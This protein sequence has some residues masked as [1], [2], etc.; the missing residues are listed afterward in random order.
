MRSSLYDGEFRKSLR[1][2]RP[3]GHFSLI[4]TLDPEHLTTYKNLYFYLRIIFTTFL[5][6]KPLLR[7]LLPGL[8]RSLKADSHLSGYRIQS[9]VVYKETFV[10]EHQFFMT[11]FIR[12]HNDRG[13]YTAGI[14]THRYRSR[15]VCLLR[16]IHMTSG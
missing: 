13:K 11:V 16:L 5:F 14:G 15:N 12:K 7:R 9:K 8:V 10:G 4:H 6:E 2:A 1:L 3:K